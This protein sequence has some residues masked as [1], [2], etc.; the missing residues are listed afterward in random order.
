VTI[1][2]C[3]EDGR[4]L[5]GEIEINLSISSRL[6]ER[7]SERMEEKEVLFVLNVG[8]MFARS[9]SN[10]HSSSSVNIGPAAAP[11]RVY[12]NTALYVLFVHGR[13]KYLAQRRRTSVL[14]IKRKVK[15]NGMNG[16]KDTQQMQ[17]HAL[18]ENGREEKVLHSYLMPEGINRQ[19]CHT[20]KSGASVLSHSIAQLSCN[21]LASSSL[22][23]SLRQPL[24]N[25]LFSI[26]F[27][28]RP[29]CV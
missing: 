1:V 17:Q 24:E 19:L 14:E 5:Q 23:F 15:E 20:L 11:A 22:F 27:F 6:T 2:A 26:S 12:L 9:V 28:A 3:R 16:E 25:L 8:V 7:E 29:G 10:A 18:R 4:I 21:S 13:G